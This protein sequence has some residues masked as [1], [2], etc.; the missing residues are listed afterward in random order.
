MSLAALAVAGTADASMVKNRSVKKTLT[1]QRQET[2]LKTPK[3]AS[4]AKNGMRKAPAMKAA[5]EEVSFNWGYCYEPNSA[6]PL[7]AGLLKGAIMLTAE[8]ATE[9]AG[10]KLSA[11]QVAN[12]TTLEYVNPVKEVTV[13][14]SESLDGEPFMSATGEMGPD[15]FEYSSIELP[16][17]YVIKADTPVYIGYTMN[18]PTPEEAGLAPGTEIFPIVVD[19]YYPESD[20][21][22]YVYSRMT[23][24]DYMGNVE[25][26]D[27]YNWMSIG[28]DVGNLCITATL[29]GDMFPVNN[30]CIEEALF[31]GVVGFDVPFSVS[32]YAMNL[33]VNDV[34]SYELVLKIGDQEPQVVTHEPDY[35]VGY[36]GYDI[37]TVSFRCLTEGR[38]VPY[39]MYISK[40]NGVEIED[41]EIYDGT[42][43]CLTEGYQ[44]NILIEEG[45]GTWCGYCVLGI[46]G[47]EYMR[48]NFGDKGFIGIAVHGDDEMD[49]MGY[50]KA[51]EFMYD[52]Y[53]GFPEAF[54]NRDVF[55]SIYPTPEDLENVYQGQINVPAFATIEAT[56]TVDPDDERK[57]TLHT[58]TKFINDEEDSWYGL[59]FTVVED[60]V[61]PYFQTNY[62]SGETE[63]DYGWGEQKPYV[64]MYYN[65]VARNCSQP[66][67]MAYWF[68]DDIE[69][70]KEY[71][72]DLE[73]ELS[74]VTDLSKYRIV[75]MVTNNYSMAVENSCEVIP[76]SYMSVP[77]L[78]E[79]EASFN[80]TGGKGRLNIDSIKEASVF[81]ANGV[82]VAS[83][84]RCASLELP[85]GVYIVTANG[86]SRKVV[87]R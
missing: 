25:Y 53:Y 65:D 87:V 86:H 7:E 61:G 62:L 51:Y 82:Q 3:S 58:T 2:T 44:R 13:W 28:E 19:F 60:N 69:A 35:Y 40:V 47:M 83:G 66:D 77:N 23:S 80:V 34:D 63:D 37:A 74:D 17:E 84:V 46:T 21:S 20:D 29:T 75:A 57:V 59:G 24:V 67:G 48:E 4:V 39:E 81:T 9:I 6:I 18:V 12:P 73:V 15:G 64:P 32:Y 56:M 22:A 31:P 1:Q 78:N 76:D 54:A 85:A 43:M 70:E 79:A 52:Y 38:A 42:L 68:P 26:G 45:T 10:A 16:E 8:D 30:M 50:G 36:K 33:G 71:D 72:V 41:P 11:I 5:G 49:V 55:S 27:S 14:L